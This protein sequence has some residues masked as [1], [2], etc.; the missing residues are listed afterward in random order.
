MNNTPPSRKKA[1]R[2]F[3]HLFLMSVLAFIIGFLM[4]YD[5]ATMQDNTWDVDDVDGSI[6]TLDAPIHDSAAAA[7]EDVPSTT[8][9]L[10]GRIALRQ[11]QLN[12]EIIREYGVFGKHIFNKINLE[13]IIQLSPLSQTKLLRKIMIKIVL[14]RIHNKANNDE[15]AEG[16]QPAAPTFHWVTAGDSSAAGHGNAYSQ[17]YT[18]ILQS[19]ASDIFQSAGIKF[20]ASNRAGNA[21]SGMEIAFCMKQIF[22]ADVDAL[23]WDFMPLDTNHFD[24][25]SSS[26]GLDPLLFGEMVGMTYPELPMLY[27]LGKGAGVEVQQQII[28]GLENRGVGFAM[29]MEASLREVALIFLPNGNDK[30]IG[31]NQPAVVAKFHC[32]GA[33]E[34]FEACDDFTQMYQCYSK[35]GGECARVKYDVAKACTNSRYQTPWNDGFKMHRLKGRLLGYHLI[36]MLCLAT[37]ELNLLELKQ[38]NL[39]DSPS[40]TLDLLRNEEEVGGFL[41]SKTTATMST[42]ESSWAWM[43]LKK[44]SCLNAM[45]ILQHSNQSDES[46]PIELHPPQASLCEEFVP[47]Q[48]A[49]FRTSDRERWIRLDPALESNEGLREVM[50]GVCFHASR[51]DADQCEIDPAF[52]TD[53]SITADTVHMSVHGKLA[54]ELKEIGGCYFLANKRGLLWREAGEEFAGGITIR[55]SN[56]LLASSFFALY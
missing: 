46:L 4:S 6:T 16:N 17:S 34:G 53:A 52:T 51:C 28:G 32:N 8:L 41:F 36:E 14:G 33:I 45:S 1:L 26:R 24:P 10:L 42:E 40:E 37:L 35:E 23:S 7:S 11:R 48:S 54:S 30:D 39:R 2:S 9:E 31:A 12:N 13:K 29:M 38:P 55:T 3:I 50:Y 20:V 43:K 18:S 25:L 19:T 56:P 15:G 21:F 5:A 27:F 47:F 44:P 22:G 49:F